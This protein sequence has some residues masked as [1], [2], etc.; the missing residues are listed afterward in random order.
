MILRVQRCILLLLLAGCAQATQTPRPVNLVA[1]AAQAPI[2]DHHEHLMSPTAAAHESATP[3]PAVTLPPELA[4][5]LASRSAVW[6]DAA[7]LA[8]LYTKDAVVYED[9]SREW[10]RGRSAASAH[11][12]T[13]FARAHRIT[14]VAFG[15]QGSGAYITGYFSRDV[16]TGVRHFGQVHLS[17]ARGADGAWRIAAETPA[18][19]GPQ[20]FAAV[21][22]DSL[23]AEMDAAGIRRAAVLSV[24]YMFGEP[25]L[26][27]PVTDGIAKVRAENDWVSAEVARFPE[28]LVGFC[29]FAALSDYA[30]AELER[31]ARLPGMR[32]LKLHFSNSRV[33]VRN[34]AHVEKLR[35]VFRAANA[36]GLAIVA[37][38][39]V[40]RDAT[41]GREHARIFLEQI[42]PE[43]PDVVVQIA[44][45]A[46]GGPGYTDPALA[47]FAEAVEAGDPRTKNLYFDVATVAH[48][49]SEEVLRTFA[50]RIRQIG[51]DRVLF[52]SDLA[53]PGNGNP[54]AK[55]A[56]AIFRNTVPLTAEEIRRIGANVAPYLRVR[57]ADPG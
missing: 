45:F 43:A 32:G 18:F 8:R 24:A 15:V 53:L 48:D 54:Q 16:A 31:C 57:S 26:N 7:G 52:G 37:H 3:L 27:P 4:Q 38:T 39:W 33:D 19:P 56:W 34:P 12:S 42:L 46:G 28:R 14:P 20:V 17:L 49:Q 13:L 50:G 25:G 22:A 35:R 55:E 29:S 23:I 1:A 10:L 40:S 5:L 51:V 36:R 41:Y 6:N 9:R 2:A 44:H 11:V 21:T 47:A 30:L